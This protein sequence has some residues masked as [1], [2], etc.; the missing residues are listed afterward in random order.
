MTQI[1]LGKYI[2]D[3]YDDGVLVCGQ[4]GEPIVLGRSDLV[5]LLEAIDE[6]SGQTEDYPEL[7][8]DCNSWDCF[9]G[10]CGTCGA[11]L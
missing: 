10:V 2:A 3:I 1:T 8:D 7:C 4:P 5:A 9:D 11:S 6:N